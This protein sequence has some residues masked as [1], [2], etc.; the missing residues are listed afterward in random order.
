[1][2][3]ADLRSRGIELE[4][5][6]TRLRWRPAFL[7]TAPQADLFDRRTVT[8]LIAGQRM[9]MANTHRLFALTMIELWRHEYRVSIASAP[10]EPL[11]AMPLAVGAGA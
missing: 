5:D 6:G 1:M 10:G 11:A 8:Q 7:V 2:R 4:T 9:G 3:V